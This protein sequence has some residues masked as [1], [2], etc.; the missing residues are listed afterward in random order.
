MRLLFSFVLCLVSFIPCFAVQQAQVER[1]LTPKEEV[2]EIDLEIERLQE[3]Q[4]KQKLIR[5][6]WN[7]LGQRWQFQKDMTQEAKRAFKN[8]EDAQKKI[9]LNEQHIQGLKARKQQLIKDN[10]LQG[11]A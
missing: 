8:A 2:K 10:D 3:E 4:T 6:R 11:S 9:E 5:A 1:P 7:D